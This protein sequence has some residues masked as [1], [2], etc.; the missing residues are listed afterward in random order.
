M[1]TQNVSR[2]ISLITAL[3]ECCRSSKMVVLLVHVTHSDPLQFACEA[4][5]QD[6]PEMITCQ[7]PQLHGYAVTD[8]SKH[9]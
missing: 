6:R 4:D 3:H 7:A 5:M 2:V 1:C 8:S 9:A